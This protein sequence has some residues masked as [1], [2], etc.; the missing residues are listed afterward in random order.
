MVR[1]RSR[2][3]CSPASLSLVQEMDVQCSKPS[4]V[5]FVFLQA[6]E[7]E[8]SMTAFSASAGSGVDAL[9]RVLALLYYQTVNKVQ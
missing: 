4:F 8:R 6:N 9:S 3:A 5:V 1:S 2:F 7:D